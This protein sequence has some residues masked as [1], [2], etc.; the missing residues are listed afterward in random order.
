ML[1]DLQDRDLIVQHSVSGQEQNFIFSQPFLGLGR[2][3]P[4]QPLTRPHHANADT[5]L[6]GY[7]D[8]I[9]LTNANDALGE[10]YGVE[11]N[12]LLMHSMP[13]LFPDR[14][15]AVQVLRELFVTRQ[16]S[17]ATYHEHT[18][19]L[20]RIALFKAVFNDADHMARIFLAVSSQVFSPPGRR[21]T[22]RQ[23]SVPAFI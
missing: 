12:A 17:F 9:L 11:K 8:D 10:L 4:L 16:S 23:R 22:Q 3:V 1:F 14:S 21:E 5:V 19:E 20:L 2:M 6:N 18:G 15:A 13:V 7:L